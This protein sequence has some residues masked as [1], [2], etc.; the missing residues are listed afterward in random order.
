MI[1]LIVLSAVHSRIVK[2]L[3]RGNRVICYFDKVA[4]AFETAVEQQICHRDRCIASAIV[5]RWMRGR[6]RR[7]GRK[8]QIPSD[9][10]IDS[11]RKEIVI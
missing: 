11:T 8:I 3:I 6:R 2:F 7:N 10:R 1:D 9:Q 5:L 4:L